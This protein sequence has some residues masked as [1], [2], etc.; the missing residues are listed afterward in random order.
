MQYDYWLNRWKKGEIGFHQNEINPYLRQYWQELHLSHGSEVL[1][2]LC[3]KSHDMLWLQEKK[4]SVLGI[5]LSSTAVQAFFKENGYSAHHVARGKFD[6]F[7]ASG[8]SILCGNFFN[9]NK[10]DLINVRAVYDRASLIALPSEIR[11]RYVRHLL[12]ILPPA[13]RILLITLDYPQSE[14][15]G[16]PFAVSPSEVEALYQKHA[17]IR[18]LTQIDVLAQNPHFQERGLSRLQESVFLL[19]LN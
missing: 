8:I 11:K 18:L 7:E 1:V 15:M 9:L 5:E 13:A 6:H 12:H 14:M 4:Y 2:P 10:D 17:E 16:P 3:G 19:T